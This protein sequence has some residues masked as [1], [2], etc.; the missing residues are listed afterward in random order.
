MSFSHTK[1]FGLYKS[2]RSYLVCQ[3]PLA[4]RIRDADFDLLPVGQITWKV[5]I[6]RATPGKYQ[7][8]DGNKSSRCNAIHIIGN[9]VILAHR[10]AGGTQAQIAKCFEMGTSAEGGAPA[11]LI[12]LR[13][14]RARRA[15]PGGSGA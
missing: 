3:T 8:I 15:I 10:R 11:Y 9:E 4:F 14:L 5:K 2:K 12:E 1:I 13:E 6:K 7:Q